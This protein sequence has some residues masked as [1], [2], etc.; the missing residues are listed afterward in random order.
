M[1]FAKYSM[2]WLSDLIFPAKCVGC[3]EFPGGKFRGYLCGRC[4]A[5]IKIKNSFECIGCKKSVPLGK[6][7]YFC[8]DG[9]SIDQLLVAADY[10][11]FKVEALLKAIKYRFIKDLILPAFILVKKYL[12][13]FNLK[14]EADLFQGRPL[15]VPIPLHRARY[16][17]RGFNQSEI[18]AGLLADNF[19]MHT[20]S[21][22]IVRIKK[23]KPQAEIEDREE[24]MKNVE[25]FFCVLRPEAVRGRTVLLVDDICTTGATLNEAAKVLKA[26]GAKKV[27]GLVVAR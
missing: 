13:H 15:V 21:D 19:Q 2:K 27:V 12:K 26:S 6:T 4:M 7:C 20:R 11:D 23:S 9:N 1:N 5:S 25:S 10:K 8:R 14:K 17:W 22:I 3:G 18:L 24:R 16:N